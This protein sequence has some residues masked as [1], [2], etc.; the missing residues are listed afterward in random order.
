MCLDLTDAHISGGTNSKRDLTENKIILKLQYCKEY[1][2]DPST[3]PTDDETATYMDKVEIQVKMVDNYIDF[4]EKDSA[5]SIKGLIYDILR[6][7]VDTWYHASLL[8]QI[9]LKTNEANFYDDYWSFGLFGSNDVQKEFLSVD[10]TDWFLSDTELPFMFLAEVDLSIHKNISTRA[11]SNIFDFAS[12]LGGL[13]GALAVLFIFLCSFF[14]PA[15]F[16]RSIMRHN[17]HY[18]SNTEKKDKRQK[19]KFA[20]K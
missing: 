9:K 15:M 13:Q 10:T 12:D 2:E 5:S 20:A 6:L 8:T 11:V 14:S 4:N 17:F 18:D 16:S 3:C 19:S 7:H 1:A